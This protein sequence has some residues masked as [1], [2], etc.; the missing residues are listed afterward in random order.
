[1]QLNTYVGEALTEPGPRVTFRFDMCGKCFRAMNVR[2]PHY[3]GTAPVNQLTVNIN[4][5]TSESEGGN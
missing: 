5:T 1:M 3:L 2:H 4:E